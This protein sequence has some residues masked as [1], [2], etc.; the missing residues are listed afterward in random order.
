MEDCL[1]NKPQEVIYA[2]PENGKRSEGLVTFRSKVGHLAKHV[3]EAKNKA[4]G[5]DCGNQRSKDFG[6]GAHGSLQNVC[7]LKSG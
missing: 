1:A 2:R 3:S 4:A 6:N 7:V 5:N